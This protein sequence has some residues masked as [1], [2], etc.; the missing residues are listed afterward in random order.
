MPT[1]ARLLKTIVPALTAA[2]AL[3]L[4]AGPELVAHDDSMPGQGQVPLHARDSMRAF[5]GEHHHDQ[6]LSAQSISGCADGQAGGFPCANVD[7]MALLPLAQIGGGNGNDVWGWTDP[8]TGQEFALMGLTN[9][10]AF[11]D[12][13]DPVNPV[14]YGRLPPPPGVA[15]SSWRDIKVYADHAFIGSEALGSGLQVFDLTRLRAGPSLAQPWTQ[16]AHYTGFS[17]S[18]NVVINEATGY[19]YG[20]GTNN[21]NCGRGLHFVDIADPANPQAAGCYADDGYTHDAQCVV[22]AGPDTQ[23]QGREICFAYN[24]DTLTVVDVT[25]KAAPQQLSRTAYPNRGYTHQ[26]WLTEDHAWLLMDDE[27]DELNVAAVTNTRTLIWDVRDLDAPLYITDYIGPS[28]SIDHN[29]YVVGDHVFQ[30]NYRSGLR[31]LDISD[32]AN[33]NLVEVGY[34]D[35][36]P[37]DDGANFNGAW[38]VYPYFASGTVVVSGIEQGLFVLRPRLEAGGSPPQVAILEPTDNGPALS[39]TVPVRID[40]SDAED[41]AGSLLVDW[42]IDGG[43]WQPAAWDGAEYAAAWDTA[44]APDGAHQLTAR[45]IDSDLSEAS[46]THDLTVLNGTA[47]FTVAVSSVTVI[48]GRGSRN[49]GEAVVVA[50]DAGGSP[51]AGVAIGGS[52]SGDWSGAVGGQSDGAGEVVLATPAV[53]NLGFVAFCVDS[54]A[55]AGWTWD[56]AGSSLCADSNGG[57]GAA[58]AVAGRVTIAGTADGISSAAVAADS[59]QATTTDAFGNYQLAGVPVGNRVISATASGYESQNQAASVTEGA[60]AVVDFALVESP[61][62]GVGAI[63]GSVHSSSGAKLAGAAVQVTGGSSSLTNNGG[64][65]S[66]QNVAAGS[67]TVTA[68]LAGYTPVAQVVNVQAG[69][70][71]TL[72]FTLTPD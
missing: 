1:V 7:L 48:H 35:V 46:A 68:S 12:V 51:L 64:K 37:A 59:G 67:Q 63:R 54:A 6:N 13:T 45:A 25:N 21:S 72:D 31:I 41:A 53:K 17:T 23:H 39:G 5:A 50:R 66:I 52:F 47:E 28:T 36:Y 61:A 42:R 33:G 20:V 56:S 40:A 2:A 11:V 29:Q 27:L 8:L 18:H 26:G 70:S 65:Y 57:G 71:V 44:T 62:G 43:A 38:S 9:G 19:A 34:F 24:E 15:S 16:T 3:L 55:K 58:G 30:A 69:G 32:I 60:T 4:A 10:T 49:N 14:Y 22:Y